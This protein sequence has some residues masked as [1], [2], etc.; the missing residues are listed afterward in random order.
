[1]LVSAKPNFLIAV[2]RLVI[3]I[4]ILNASM[5]KM[6]KYTLLQLIIQFWMLLQKFPMTRKKIVQF[7]AMFH[8]LFKGR[9]MMD[10][11]GLRDMFIMLKVK[12][13]P[14]KHCTDYLSW[15]IVELMNDL[16]L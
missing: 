11:E 7:A 9:A 6:N 10:C 8:L 14:K 1:M 2:W 13:T 16:L 15:G 5:L 3:F 4:L 12:H